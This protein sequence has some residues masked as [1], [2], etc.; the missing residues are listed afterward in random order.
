MKGDEMMINFKPDGHLKVWRKSE[1]WR[2][3]CLSYISARP[4]ATLKLMVWGCMC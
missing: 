1:K 4:N 3:E 2:P